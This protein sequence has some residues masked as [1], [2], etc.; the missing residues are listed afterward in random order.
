MNQQN[1]T[2]VTQLDRFKS[3]LALMFERNELALP[4]S[5][6]PE[7]F[8]NAAIVA[9]QDS[10]Y[11]QRCTPQSVFKALRTLAV[12]GLVPDGREAAIVPFKDAAQAMPMVYGLIK[13]ARNSGKVKTLWAEVVYEGE[14]LSIEIVDGERKFKHTMEDGSPIDAMSRGGKIRG[15]FAV[16]KLEDGSIDFQPMSFDEIEKRRKASANQRGNGPTGIWEKWYEEMAKK[17]VIRNL[18]KRLPMSSEDVGRLMVEEDATPI[19][20]VTPEPRKT[21]SQRISEAADDV[22]KISKDNDLPA[23]DINEDVADAEFALDLDAL[24]LSEAFPGDDAFTEGA[25][26]AQAGKERDTCPY[27]DTGAATNWVGG[28]TQAQEAAQ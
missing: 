18:C 25:K 8:R 2:A 24:D 3:N 10:A 16:A 17:T 9:Y 27:E 6:K 22:G 4:S 20:D 12:A 26:A 1:Q 19:K 23:R 5:V 28:W 7:A 15:A 11:L 21:L 14:L 13:V